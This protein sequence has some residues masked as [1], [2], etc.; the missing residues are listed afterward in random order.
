MSIS[1]KAYLNI[2][3]NQ[4]EIRR[5]SIDSDASTSYVY[6]VEKIRNVYPSVKRDNIKLFWKGLL[7]FTQ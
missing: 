6:L 2:A 5:F 7:N 4:T 1:V 3:D